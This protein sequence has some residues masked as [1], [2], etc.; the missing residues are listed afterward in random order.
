MALPSPGESLSPNKVS[1]FFVTSETGVRS[2]VIGNPILMSGLRLSGSG[3]HY[4]YVDIYTNCSR[5]LTYAAYVTCTSC[6]MHV[7]SACPSQSRTGSVRWEKVVSVQFG[8]TTE[9]WRSSYLAPTSSQTPG[10]NK[11]WKS[12]TVYPLP[13]DHD[14]CYGFLYLY[15]GVLLEAQ[16]TCA[17]PTL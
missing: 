9:R 15:A 1:A 13:L 6:D 2:P 8:E 14:V 17:W 7:R 3:L 5:T 12:V 4:F 16:C 10:R 11:G